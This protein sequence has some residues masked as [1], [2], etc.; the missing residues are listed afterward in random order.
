MTN[1]INTP[2]TLPSGVELPNRL[3]KAAMTERLASPGNEVTDRH[4][5]LYKA[6]G[7]WRHRSPDH[8]KCA[9]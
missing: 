3:V 5:Q 4:L 6:W 2:L 8:W 1:S 9:G 7:G